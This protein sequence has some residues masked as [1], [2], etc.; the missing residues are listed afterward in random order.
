M[1]NKLILCFCICPSLLPYQRVNL[2]THFYKT[3]DSGLSFCN[4]YVTTS[5]MKIGNWK[6]ETQ[7]CISDVKGDRNSEVIDCGWNQ[8][9]GHASTHLAPWLETARASG[10]C[11]ELMENLGLLF[12][13]ELGD[14]TK[15]CRQ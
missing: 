1:Q 3:E 14:N 13:E 9:N 7:I 12:L 11:H 4:N 10:G 8:L 5:F 6:E 15:I 2:L